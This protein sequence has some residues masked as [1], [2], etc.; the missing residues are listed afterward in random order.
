MKSKEKKLQWLE[1]KHTG[2][3]KLK[4]KFTI[5]TGLQILRCEGQHKITL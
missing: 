3:I 5:N 4:E 1:L 2:S